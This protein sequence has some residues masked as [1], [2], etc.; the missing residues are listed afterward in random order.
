MLR[1]HITDRISFP[2]RTKMLTIHSYT[3]VVE[4]S[5]VMLGYKQRRNIR[6][7]ACVMTGGAAFFVTL[8]L[9]TPA[10]D[11]PSSNV[12]VIQAVPRAQVKGEEA[13]RE[14]ECLKLQRDARL[15]RIPDD[16]KR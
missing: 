14:D 4:P 9:L 8:Q 2:A 6:V 7:V 15:G 3:L 12:T 10:P 1:H 11:P 13:K 16:L 5:T